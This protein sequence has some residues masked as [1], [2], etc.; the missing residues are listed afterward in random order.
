[1][2]RNNK[3]K[4]CSWCKQIIEKENLTI[5]FRGV[6]FFHKKCYDTGFAESES[7]KKWC[8]LLYKDQEKAKNFLPDLDNSSLIVD[9]EVFYEEL[10]IKKTKIK[11]LENELIKTEEKKKEIKNENSQTHWIINLVPQSLKD[12]SNKSLKI[13]FFISAFLIIC[14]IWNIFKFFNEIVN[15]LRSFIL[16]LSICY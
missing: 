9:Y 8:A 2:E 6:Y 11:E 14:L 5:E 13:I 15:F 3:N 10:E 4:S 1:V 16:K 12:Y 7:Y